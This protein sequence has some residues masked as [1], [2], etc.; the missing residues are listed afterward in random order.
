MKYYTPI[1]KLSLFIPGTSIYIKREDLIP[2][3]FGGNKVRIAKEYFKDMDAKGMDCM[4]GY[5]NARSN[6]CRVLANMNF[7]RGG[8]C[9]IISPSED[10]GSRVVTT[11][12]KI[13]NSCGVT[14]H[15]CDK[16]CVAKTVEKTIKECKD[17]GLSPYYMYGDK[18]GNGNEAVP[19]RAYAKAYE[20][21]SKQSEELGIKFDYIFLATGTGMTQA[22]LLAGKLQN[23]GKERI[24][25]ISVSRE[26]EQEQNVLKKYISEYFISTGY[27]GMVDDVEV[28]DDFLCGGYGKFDESIKKTIKEVF[29]K[30]GIPLDPTYTGK[31][32]YGM[33]EIIKNK[34]LTGNVLFIHTGGTPLFF[35]NINI[36]SECL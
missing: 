36:L 31:A 4:I 23:N 14:F 1:H 3:S 2:F 15:Y 9:H 8:I 33:C 20:E 7:A 25:G 34:E 10:D 32:F 30:D 35:D 5:G 12:S 11:N 27:K 26:K 21:I 19:V 16:Q 29:L 18:F 17:M 24:I 6:L 28:Y 22:G 13:V